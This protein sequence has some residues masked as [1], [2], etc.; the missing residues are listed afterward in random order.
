MG[1][2]RDRTAP[3]RHSAAA[4][5]EV[6]ERVGVFVWSLRHTGTWTTLDWLSRKEGCDG[7]SEARHLTKVLMGEVVAHNLG[8]IT[9]LCEWGGSPIIHEHVEWDRS[10]PQVDRLQL[11]LALLLPTVIPLRD[12]LAACLTCHRR[13]EQA[14]HGTTPREQLDLWEALAKVWELLSFTRAPTVVI[15]W[16]LVRPDE[17]MHQLVS[18]SQELGW[19]DDKADREFAEQWPVSNSTGEYPAKKA[20]SEGDW[21]WLQLNLPGICRELKSREDRLRPWLEGCGYSDLLWWS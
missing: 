15:P 8:H 18:A 21:S 6:L 7:F 1:S 2:V 10:E 14:G 16:D 20:Y 13:M 17:R 3:R 12:P 9:L 5:G 19:R 4:R 11:T